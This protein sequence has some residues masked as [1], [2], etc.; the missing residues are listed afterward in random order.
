GAT[1]AWRAQHE[2]DVALERERA[3]G[4]RRQRRLAFVVGV[5]LAALAVMTALAAYALSQRST[6]RHETSVAVT[7]RQLALTALGSGKGLNTQLHTSLRRQA[8]LRR[9]AVVQRTALKRTNEKLRA[10]EAQLQQSNSEL[11][12]SEAQLEQTNSELKT[13][14]TQ[15]EQTN[16][17]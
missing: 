3:A 2:A 5:V 4:R 12:T 1:L 9:R 15:L 16:S 11:K 8:R 6:A 14:E 10:S 13:S 17:E 7:Q